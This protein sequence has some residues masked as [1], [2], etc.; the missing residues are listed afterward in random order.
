MDKWEELKQWLSEQAYLYCQQ[1]RDDK[2]QA[3]FSALSKMNELEQDSADA[4]RG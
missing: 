2:S 1:Q 3:T 4:L